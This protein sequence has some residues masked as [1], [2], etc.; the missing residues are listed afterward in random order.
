[1]QTNSQI[2]PVRSTWHEAPWALHLE[3]QR[4]DKNSLSGC[5][6]PFLIVEGKAFSDRERA[7]TSVMLNKISAQELWR[8]ISKVQAVFLVPSVVSWTTQSHSWRRQL[9]WAVLLADLGVP[10]SISHAL[11]MKT[12]LARC[13]VQFQAPKFFYFLVCL[14][15]FTKS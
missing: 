8:V 10:D 4:H 14:V 11:S 7:F 1:M 6:K 9:R 3:R 5:L 2:L 15:F 13:K 12:K